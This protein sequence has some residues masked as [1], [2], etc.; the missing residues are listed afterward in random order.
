MSEAVDPLDALREPIVPFDPDPVFAAALRARL[1]RALLDRTGASMT[2]GTEPSTTD[3]TTSPEG[4]IGYASV[5]LPDVTRGEAFYGSVLGWQFAAGSSAQGRQVVGLPNQ[6]IGVWGGIEHNTTYLAL[7]VHDAEQAVRRVRA[8]GGTAE[9]PSQ[10][11]F[12][13][14]AMCIDDQ[15]LAFTVFQ[16]P[17]GDRAPAPPQGPGEIVYL[18]FE[19]PDSARFRAFFGAVFGWEFT[20]GR[21]GGDRWGINGVRPLAGLSGGNAEVTVVPQ[22]VVTDLASAIERVRAA[23]G[24]A[25]EPQ[26]QPYGLS[27]DCVDDQ[28]TRFYLAQL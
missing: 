25:N 7:A 24:T 1:Q 5:W 13:M 18:T 9:D 14:A 11:P 4:D 16:V 6:H 20:A 12:G 23:G 8:A 17:A 21:A 27:T 10:E 3:S 28:G 22:Y 19:V 2:T 26:Q 15:G